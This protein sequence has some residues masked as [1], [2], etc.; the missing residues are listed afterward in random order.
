MGHIRFL[1]RSQHLFDLA[2]CLLLLPRNQGQIFRGGTL[3]QSVCD[4]VTDL[5]LDVMFA[6]GHYNHKNPVKLSLNNETP[7]LSTRDAEAALGNV[8]KD[9]RTGHTDKP[10]IVQQG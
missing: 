8:E 9:T 3:K 6:Y 7:A 10:T 2:G 1:C 4:R 5:Q